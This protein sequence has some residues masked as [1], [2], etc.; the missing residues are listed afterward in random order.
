MIKKIRCFLHKNSLEIHIP[1]HS[2]ILGIPNNSNDHFLTSVGFLILS[3]SYWSFL[4][5]RGIFLVSVGLWSKSTY[6]LPLISDKVCFRFF[7]SSSVVGSGFVVGTCW[8]VSFVL[9]SYYLQLHT[10]L[11]SKQFNDKSMNFIVITSDLSI[12]VV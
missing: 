7:L 6:P 4:I 1:I 10:K 8:N 12:Y 5:E 2:S 9:T 11:A 3:S